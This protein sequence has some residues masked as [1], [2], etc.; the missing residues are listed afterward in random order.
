MT[1]TNSDLTSNLLEE[2][3]PHLGS[4]NFL[5]KKLDNGPTNSIQFS[6][7]V[8]DRYQKMVLTFARLVIAFMKETQSNTDRQTKRIKSLLQ[9]I[10]A[11]SWA[12]CK[13]TTGLDWTGLDWTGLVTEI[14]IWTCSKTS[15]LKRRHL[16]RG[17]FLWRNGFFLFS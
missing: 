2:F 1:A 12:Y 14:P 15:N 17:H 13:G 9:L 8:E 11:F 4:K 5:V 7:R 16:K 3:E 6:R 10:T